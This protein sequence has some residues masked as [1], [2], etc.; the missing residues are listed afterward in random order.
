MK[1]IKVAIIGAGSAGLSARREV[2]KETED[3][4]VFD[5]GILGTTCARVG[6]MP[7][8]VLIQAG[9]DVYKTTKFN[10]FGVHGSEHISVNL[11]EVM[12]H[13]R[14]L[15]DRFVRAVEGGMSSWVDEHLIREYVEL[16]GL[17]SLKTETG[18][19]YEFDKIIITTGTS[20][21]APPV[22]KGYESYL[23]SSDTVFEQI[24]LPQKMAVLGMGVIGLELGQALHRLG[25]DILGISRR[26]SI[27]G[28]MNPEINEY[29]CKHFEKEMKLNFSG[30]SDVKEIDGQL[31]LILGDGSTHIVDKV[32]LANGRKLN[33]ER[34][35]LAPFLHIKDKNGLPP[36]NN[37]TFQLEEHSHIYI[38]G[39]LTGEKQ[40]LHEASDEGKIAGHNAVRSKPDR[41]LTRTPLG[42]TFSE[43]NIAFCGKHYQE[44]LDEKLEFEIGKV[45]FEGQGRSIIKLKEVG[46]LYIYGEKQTGKILGAEMIGPDNEHLAHLLAWCIQMNLTVNEVLEMPFYHPVVEE[47]MRTALRDLRGKLAVDPNILELRKIND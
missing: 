25:V 45:T 41:F 16:T 11:P 14:K 23:Y 20:P 47:G 1:K 31:E 39:D 40:L 13:V 22:L 3:Y 4:L 35:N 37:E 2:A 17:N 32:L 46:L 19:E 12:T 15:R 10:S 28:I 34:I 30:L 42:I 38:A 33:L 9:E 29:A 27:S 26:R 21:Y 6:C 18:T 8:K 44:L 43:P 36:I 24:D 5:G 7:S